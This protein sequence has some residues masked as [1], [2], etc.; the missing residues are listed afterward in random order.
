M[1]R[2]MYYIYDAKI[3]FLRIL[4]FQHKMIYVRSITHMYNHVMSTESLLHIL[5]WLHCIRS[6]IFGAELPPSFSDPIRSYNYTVI[7]HW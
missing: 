3:F 6:G 2:Y 1:Y 4:L 5:F 7:V